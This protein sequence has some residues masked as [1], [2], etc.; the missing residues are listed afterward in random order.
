MVLAAAFA[1]DDSADADVAVGDLLPSYVDP[2][3]LATNRLHRDDA[4]EGSKY[5]E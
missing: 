2:S 1:R 3:W 4:A 5:P